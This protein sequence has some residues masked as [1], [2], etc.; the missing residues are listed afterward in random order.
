MIVECSACAAQRDV[1][2][3]DTGTCACGCTAIE[4]VEQPR[5]WGGAAP[6]EK[7]A[8]EYVVRLT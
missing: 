6:F 7:L 4:D 3:N 2:V 8:A 1:S 5:G